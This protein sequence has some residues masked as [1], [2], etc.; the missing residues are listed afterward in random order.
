M[1]AKAGLL[2]RFLRTPSRFLGSFETRTVA[3]KCPYV[4]MKLTAAGLFGIFEIELNHFFMKQC[5]KFDISPRTFQSF[6]H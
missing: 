3:K 4:L 1:R 2:T 6:T 5:T